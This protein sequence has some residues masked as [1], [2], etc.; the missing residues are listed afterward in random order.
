MLSTCSVSSLT[1]DELNDGG[2]MVIYHCTEIAAVT[3]LTT[4]VRAGSD[5]VAFGKYRFR[6]W[7][8]S[9]PTASISEPNVQLESSTALH[10]ELTEL[11]CTEALLSSRFDFFLFR[12]AALCVR[13]V[14][15]ALKRD[16][17][18][19]HPIQAVVPF[20][21]HSLLFALISILLVSESYTHTASSHGFVRFLVKGH[22]VLDGFVE[23]SWD[24]Q[25]VL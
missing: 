8:H 10:R 21:C 19:R 13:H 24:V 15:D 9:Q 4:L 11:Y 3:L 17:T 16:K 7:T 12:S 1:R 25:Q 18:P 2:H 20:L 23:P 6:N 22:V 14:I 5:I